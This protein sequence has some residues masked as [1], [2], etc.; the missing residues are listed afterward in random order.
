LGLCRNGKKEAAD[1]PKWGNGN[2]LQ[3]HLDQAL[4]FIENPSG[5]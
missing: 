2:D 5:E 4:T 3:E 1:G